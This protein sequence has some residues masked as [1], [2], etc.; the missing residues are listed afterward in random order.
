[1]SQRRIIQVDWNAVFWGALIL[2]EEGLEGFTL[3]RYPEWTKR[4]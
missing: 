3:E 4:T 2:P 1:M